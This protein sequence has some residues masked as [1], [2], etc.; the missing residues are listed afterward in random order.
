MAVTCDSDGGWDLATLCGLDEII[1]ES[2]NSKSSPR[3]L[4]TTDGLGA[5]RHTALGS[6]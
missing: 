3:L 2:P 6:R 1:L 5:S 4:Q